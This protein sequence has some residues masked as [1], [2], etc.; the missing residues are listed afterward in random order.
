MCGDTYYL[1]VMG[2]FGKNQATLTVFDDDIQPAPTADPEKQT[3]SHDESQTALPEMPPAAV[4]IDPEIEKRVL[5]KL[6]WR[7]PTL[8]GFLYLLSLLDRSNIGWVGR[9]HPNRT[10]LTTT[11]MP[12]LRA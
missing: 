5:R 6:D 3:L 7:V 9:S 11:E 10:P 12:K 4:F 1:I 8:L 2:F